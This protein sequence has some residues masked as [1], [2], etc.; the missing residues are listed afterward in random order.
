MAYYCTLEYLKTLLPTNL[1]IGTSTQTQPTLQVTGGRESITEVRAKELIALAGQ[2]IDS[3]LSPMYVTPLKKM[4][5]VEVELK[6]K[7]T[8]GTNLLYV[9]DGGQFSVGCQIKVS[10]RGTGDSY[11]I[12][13][14]YDDVPN[15][16]KIEVS[17]NLVRTYQ[18]SENWLVSLVD[19]PA[20]VP[21]ICARL[22]VA[23]IVERI[24][25]A[26]QSP[27]NS[28]HGEAMKN[29]AAA[30]LDNILQGI[31]RLHGQEHQGG[32]F[33]RSSI[34]N[35]VSTPAANFQPGGLK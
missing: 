14:L 1:T 30:E 9:R 11:T 24:F 19:Y 33:A 16:S 10:S 3:R 32:R 26:E 21:L 23:M 8:V 5:L 29:L 18:T 12:T 35:A 13:N 31:V 7:S 27:D 20:P 17:P 34:K 4:K 2:M 15:L 25:V 28:Q 6:S 22:S